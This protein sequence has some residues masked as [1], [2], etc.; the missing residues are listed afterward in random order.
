LIAKNILKYKL[1]V[2]RR[3]IFP[4]VSYSDVRKSE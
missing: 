2:L 4:P 3:S 1:I